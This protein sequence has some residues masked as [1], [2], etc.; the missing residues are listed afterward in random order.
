MGAVGCK[1]YQRWLRRLPVVEVVSPVLRWPVTWPLL[2]DRRLKMT[3]DE[4]DQLHHLWPEFWPP[5]S[6]VM[7]DG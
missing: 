3:A 2:C 5:S 6:I 1:I 4:L 7:G